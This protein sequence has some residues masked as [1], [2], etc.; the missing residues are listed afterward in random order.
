LKL[1]SN[2]DGLKKIFVTR[3]MGWSCNKTGPKDGLYI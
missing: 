1:I 2:Y 3:P